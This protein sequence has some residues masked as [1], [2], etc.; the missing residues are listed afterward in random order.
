MARPLRLTPSI[1][2]TVTYA[3]SGRD[4][5]PHPTVEGVKGKRESRASHAA[6]VDT[7]P[8]QKTKRINGLVKIGQEG[9]P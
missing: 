8:V 3:V 1:V 5:S 9:S 4:E 6:T 7:V 2:D